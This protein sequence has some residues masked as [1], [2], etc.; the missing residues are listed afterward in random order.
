M[1]RLGGGGEEDGKGRRAAAA[2]TLRSRE[3]RASARPLVGRG[4]AWEREGSTGGEEGAGELEKWEGPSRTGGVGKGAG[5]KA[6]GESRLFERGTSWKGLGTE[7]VADWW[8][9][10]RGGGVVVRWTEWAG[11]V[12][13]ARAGL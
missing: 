3:K 2:G 4:E 12:Q 6:G 8:S 11:E 9:A 5:L 1:E 7:V 10:E 13:R